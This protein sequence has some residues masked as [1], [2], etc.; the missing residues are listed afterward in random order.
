MPLSVLD[1]LATTLRECYVF[2]NPTLHSLFVYSDV[3]STTR[4]YPSSEC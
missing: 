1:L 4:Q 2:E 3:I